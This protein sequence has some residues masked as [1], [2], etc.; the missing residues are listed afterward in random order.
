MFHG[1]ILMLEE[2]LQKITEQTA[3]VILE[4][5]Q[6]GAGFILPQNDYLK[7]GESKMRRSWRFAHSR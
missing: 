1:S 5:I 4:T 2:D 3:A 7:K 6:G